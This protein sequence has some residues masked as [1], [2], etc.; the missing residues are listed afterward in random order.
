MVSGI[1]SNSISACV[2]HWIFNSQAS[3]EEQRGTALVWSLQYPVA[4]D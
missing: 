1:Q 3:Q 2:K 4:G